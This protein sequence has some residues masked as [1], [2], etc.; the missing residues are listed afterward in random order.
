M[1]PYMITPIKYKNKTQ[2]AET[3][4][5]FFHT[6]QKKQTLTSKKAIYFK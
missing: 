3:H 1:A 6:L 4:P 5:Q 2:I